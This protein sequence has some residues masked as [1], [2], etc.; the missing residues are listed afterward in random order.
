MT[1]QIS[2]VKGVKRGEVRVALNQALVNY[3][4]KYIGQGYALN[5]LRAYLIQQG[6][7]YSDVDA[8][9]SFVYSQQQQRQP[10]QYQQLQQRTQQQR[11]AGQMQ[12]AQPAQQ[13]PQIV[14]QLSQYIQQLL[15][16]VA[17]LDVLRLRSET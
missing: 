4:R 3:I 16:N 6:Y 12:A 11:Q 7:P 9:I 13:Q 8:A 5:S 2:F 10:Q 1:P 17:D 14:Q 15:D